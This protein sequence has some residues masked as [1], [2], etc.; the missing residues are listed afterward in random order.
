MGGVYGLAVGD[1][2]HRAAFNGVWQLPYSFQLSGV[3]FFG[4][5]ERL[6]TSWGTDVRLRGGT[7]DSENRLRPNG[8]IVPRN[9][10]VGHPI[11]RVDLRIQRRFPLGGRAG[12]DG[13]V[14]VFNAFN[15]ANYGAYT[16]QEVSANYGRP[17]RAGGVE[18]G[19]RTL[20][21]GFRL[22]F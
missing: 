4:S 15:H 3:Y 5:G 17:S 11:Q 1:Q 22:V 19:P 18:Y 16:T 12:V 6:A 7:Q 8:T 21:L 10:F 2:R 20:Q 9:N 14:E 13:I